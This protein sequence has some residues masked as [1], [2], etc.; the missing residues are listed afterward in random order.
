MARRD[1]DA[2]SPGRSHRYSRLSEGSA[3]ERASGQI[4][5][6]P[7]RYRAI[8]RSGVSGTGETSSTST[9][10]RGDSECDRLIGRSSSSSSSSAG[11]EGSADRLRLLRSRSQLA[12][13][14]QAEQKLASVAA[15]DGR[16]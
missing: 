9:A 14:E 10:I 2:R 7:S 6:E 11:H 4:D 13:S 5:S 3:G 1:L 16:R 8:A 12:H 15:G